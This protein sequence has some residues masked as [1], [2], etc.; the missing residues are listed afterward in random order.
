MS[1]VATPAGE[2]ADPQG[3]FEAIRDE[4]GKLLAGT[5]RLIEFL[6]IALL[7]NGH[8]LL[9][10]VPGVAKTT[11][12][13]GFARASGLESNRI[14]MT[15]D[16]LPA[17]ITGTHVYREPAGVFEI[18]R[19]PIFASVVVVD[20]INRATPKTQSALLEAMQER[21]V[22]IEGETLS[23]P[24]P[25]M[26]VATQN[27]IEMEGVFSLPEAQRDRFTFKLTVDL[28]DR[29]IE[30]TVLDRFDDD[31]DLGP[32][33]VS[34]V[35]DAAAIEAARNTVAGV[36]VAD[37]VKEYILD[38]VAA[39][40]DHP[41]VAHGGSPR[42]TLAFV[43]GAKARA[44]IHG[45]EYVIPDDVKALAEP[46]FVHRLVLETDAELSAVAPVDV[47]AALVEDVAPP[48]ATA[49]E[50]AAVEEGE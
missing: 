15:P 39:S 40:R 46:V 49:N 9:E 29:E 33:D 47:V 4:T 17:D 23:L 43:N 35:V 8:V 7:T 11:M 13:T 20:E 36:H 10:G 38:L 27:P 12:A 45:R 6:T 25:F 48:G 22:T 5:D 18:Q 41:D 16:V 37:P 26:V 44:A 1:D 24:R 50:L 34:P 19:G 31:P 2:G 30:R 28:P 14:Q 3:I 32:A 21:S 42:A